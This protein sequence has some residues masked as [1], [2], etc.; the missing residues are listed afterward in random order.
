MLYMIIEKFRNGDPHPVYQRFRD[1]GRLAPDG[2]VYVDSWV[3]VDLTMCY[4]VMRTDDRALLDEWISNWKDIV[5]FE[6][7]PVITSPEARAR[8]E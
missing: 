7:I 2:L 4:Q 5:D 1:R 3:T 6:V 8:T